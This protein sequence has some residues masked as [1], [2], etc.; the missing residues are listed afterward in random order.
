MISTYY[1]EGNEKSDYI[2]FVFTDSLLHRIT[3]Q[4]ESEK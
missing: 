1:S 2:Y 4:K 3:Q